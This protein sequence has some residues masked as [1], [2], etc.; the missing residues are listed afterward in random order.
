MAIKKDTNSSKKICLGIESTAHTF[1]IGIVDFEGNVLSIVNDTYVPDTGGLH[2]RKVVEH[3]NLIF[4]NVLKQ[5]LKQA[6]ISVRNL[7]LIAFSQGPGLGPCLRIGAGIART[8]SQ[9]LKIPIVG[10]N[11]CI[12]HVEIGRRISGFKDPLTLYVSGGNTIVSA[13]ESGRYQVFGET[14]DLAVGNMIDMVARDLGLPHPGGPKIEKLALSGSK[15]IELP[16]VVKGMDL[17]FSGLYTKCRN[18]INSSGFGT[19]YTPEDISFSLQETA[20][21]ML[22]EVTERALAHT[23]K[24]EVLLTGGV[25]ANKRLQQ[26]I[27]YISDEHDAKFFSVPLRLAGDNGAMIAWAGIL[28][29][30]NRGGMKIK[31]TAIDPKWRM[32]EVDISW[33]QKDDSFLNKTDFNPSD[34]PIPQKIDLN[35]GLL[36]DRG[37]IIKK[38]AEAILLRV[39]HFGN[40]ILVKY[41]IRKKYRIHEI[42]KML[43]D[44]R[45]VNEARTLIRVKK[46]DV[47][48]PIIHEIDKKKSC[49]YMS[50]LKGVRLKD[51][52]LK[53]DP[54]LKA[55]FKKVG[56]FVAKLHKNHQIHGDL[57]TSNIII[58]KNG[59]NMFFIDFGLSYN[60][61]TRE[62]MAVDLHLFKRVMT[63][64]HGDFFEFIFPPF[65][66]GYVNEYGIKEGTKIVEEIEDIELRGRYIKKDK[67]KRGVI[68]KTR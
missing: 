64:T 42:D 6:N 58:E 43:R 50:Y 59:K 38:G 33:R 4:L 39:N 53:K 1:G 52:I 27:K 10:A 47:P 35:P 26:M 29:Y 22:S 5:A 18:L 17:S 67:R 51:I 11:H 44:K 48:V 31:L 68:K 41:R 30:L 66:E 61:S 36:T 21:A 24:T 40:D 14:L 16:Y 65:I 12:G 56:K 15:Y 60:S 13:F 2:P 20:Y 23:E 34:T 19:D 37:N 9:K 55:I 25:A 45:T 62:D 32:D 63:S 49:I 8:L 28:H 57:T 3:H 46:F 7:D 54:E